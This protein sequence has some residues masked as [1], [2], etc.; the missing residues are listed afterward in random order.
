MEDSWRVNRDFPEF[1]TLGH[2][3]IEEAGFAIAKGCPPA[4]VFL[5]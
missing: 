4:E 3:G 5:S 2:L 1:R